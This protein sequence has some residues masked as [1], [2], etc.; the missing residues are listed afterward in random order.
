M[1]WIDIIIATV[2]VGALATVA[3][4]LASTA[5]CSRE[6]N[7]NALADIRA[8]KITGPA[9]CGV[10]T[11]PAPMPAGRKRRPIISLYEELDRKADRFIARKYRKRLGITF[12]QY[13]ACTKIYEAKVRAMEEALQ[14]GDGINVVA[15]V[16]RIVPLKQ[17]KAAT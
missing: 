3:L 17:G 12:E 14:N 15:N 9:K 10:W 6:E 2:S 4:A 16:A 1:N 11:F 5:V 13:A 7:G 8:W